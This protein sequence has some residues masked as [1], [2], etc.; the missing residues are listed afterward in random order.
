MHPKVMEALE[1]AHISYVVRNHADVPV[2]IHT[3]QDFADVLGYPLERITKSVLFCGEPQ[4]KYCMVVCSINK[5]I[6]LALLAEYAHCKRMH[7][8]STE[9]L[10]RITDYPAKGVAP[11][12]V[13]AVPVYIDGQLSA[14]PT[15]LVG[16]GTV[17]VEVELA[18][19]DLKDSTGATVVDITL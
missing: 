12:G 10:K 11:I 8:A 18:P 6:N 15:V 17:G 14:L 9:E 3:P 13:E 7:I 2:P 4:K 16:G 1:R 19:S 5:K